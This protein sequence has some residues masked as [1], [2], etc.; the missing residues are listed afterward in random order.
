[1][2]GSSIR[3]RYE[4]RVSRHPIRGV[5]EMTFT[6]DR[7]SLLAGMSLAGGLAVSGLPARAQ[8]GG[9]VVVGTWGGDYARLLTKN[10]EDPLLKPK[11]VEVVQDQ[12]SDAPRRAKMIAERR[13][14]R[15]T[16]DIHG[17]SA[18]NMFEV[19]EA[20]VVEQIDYSK[21]PNAKSLL[22]TMKYPYGV[23]HIY[24]G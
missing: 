10:I 12:A 13:L 19:N 5:T 15:G 1:M 18:A 21:L 16:V 14:P 20:G 23:G 7:R 8:S 11:G 4:P 24:S 6:I 3:A 9:R 17:L 2:S 22:P